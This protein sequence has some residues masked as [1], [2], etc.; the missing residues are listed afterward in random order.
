MTLLFMKKKLLA[1]FIVF[2]SLTSLAALNGP[3]NLSCR[4]Q[5]LNPIY[6]EATIKG[7]THSKKYNL[8]LIENYYGVKFKFE[9]SLKVQS[10]IELVSSKASVKEIN[11]IEGK[12][13]I[14]VKTDKTGLINMIC[15]NI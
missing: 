13:L 5:H 3:K 9:Y 8:V 11:I 2:S 14:E 4:M 10:S 7:P 12:Y 6:Y 15:E 1:S